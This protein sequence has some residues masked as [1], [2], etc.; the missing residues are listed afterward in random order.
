M[1]LAGKGNSSG[2]AVAEG[3]DAAAGDPDGVGV[4]AMELE[5]L[6]GEVGLGTFEPGRAGAGPDPVARSFKT[7]ADRAS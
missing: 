6:L 1:Y 7:A 3:L 5:R 2:A 4:V